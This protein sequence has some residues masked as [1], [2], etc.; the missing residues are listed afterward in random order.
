MSPTRSLLITT[1]AACSGN[2][3][4]MKGFKEIAKFFAPTAA[5]YQ[6]VLR[7]FIDYKNHHDDDVYITD[8]NGNIVTGMNP[9]AW[10]Q[11]HG[12][13]WPTLQRIAIRVFSVGTSSSTSERNFSTWSHIWSNRANSIDFQRAIKLVYVYNNLRTLQRLKANKARKDHVDVT[14]L[15][16]EIEE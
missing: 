10:W 6:T 13:A 5:D 12:A 4:V 2:I 3:K 15:D 11:L 16:D 14:W 1:T 7:E 9:K 8:D